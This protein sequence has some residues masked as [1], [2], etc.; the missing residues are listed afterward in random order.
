MPDWSYRTLF[1]PVL[2][3]LPSL[4]ARDFTLGAMGGLSRLPGGTLI[5]RTLGHMEASPILERDYFNLPLKYPVGLSGGLDPHGTAHKALAQFGFGYIEIGP[6]T[7]EPIHH[8]QPIRLH[9]ESE[10]IIYDNAWTND[11]LEAI[12]H[13]IAERKG[14]ALP[15]MLRLRHMPERTPEEALNEQRILLSEL[16]PYASCFYV[17]AVDNRWT[18]EENEQYIQHVLSI[19]AGSQT[20]LPMLLYIPLDYPYELLEQLLMNIDSSQ[21][22]GFVLGDGIQTE[23]G[24]VIGRSCLEMSKD[25]IRYLRRRWGADKTIIASGGIHEPQDALEVRQAGAD[26]VQLHSGLVYSGPGLPKRINEAV[27]YEKIQTMEEPKPVQ[28]WKSWG[29]MCLLAIGMIIG[30]I[31]AFIVAVKDVVLPYDIAFLGMDSLSIHQVNERL[32]PFMSHDRIT[33]AGTMLSIGIVYY[34][35]ARHGLRYEQHWAK[36]ALITSGSVGFVSFFLYF[37]HGYFDPLHAVMTIVILP[38]FILSMLK[39]ADKPLRKQPN[40]LNDHIWQR[41]QWGQLM[42]VA[43]GVALAI[44]GLVISLVGIT[45]V[46]VPQD[47]D[48]LQTTSDSLIESNPSLLPLIAHDRAGFGGALFSQAIA[49]LLTA[50]WGIQQGERWLWWTFLLGGIPGFAAAFGVHI[51]IGYLDFIH[52]LP[53][54]IALLLYMVGLILLYPYLMG[55]RVKDLGLGMKRGYS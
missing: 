26:L 30:G 22:A 37:G 5:I 13:Q 28:W 17:D 3:R 29:W 16:A 19:H 18:I 15:L 14:H 46:F 55:K 53:P 10:E 51:A 7:I 34:Q 36:T 20:P 24:Y 43:L 21:F 52:L 42:F 47:L 9:Q 8:N 27:I 31:L 12:K 48:Y 1:R 25:K 32:L 33:L 49:I 6:I 38:L 50:L 11:G 41:A 2:F 35:L 23:E 54:L 45:N 4:T 44:G 40:L 39:K